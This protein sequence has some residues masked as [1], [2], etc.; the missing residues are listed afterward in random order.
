MLGSTTSGNADNAL[1]AASA[2]ANTSAN[3]S[4]S[5]L[6]ALKLVASKRQQGTSPQQARR[7]KLSNKLEEQIQLAKAQQ[8]GTEFAPTKLR[9]VHDELTG[10]SSKAQVPKKIKPWWW[11]ADN[12]KTCI[13]LRYGA[14]VVEISKGKNA[15][16]TGGIAEVITSL[17][18]LK[19]AVEAGDL[20]V[21]LAAL[22]SRAKEKTD[23]VPEP[24]PVSEKRGTLK[25]PAKAA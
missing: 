20:D 14:R 24:E 15:I 5:G 19:A 12:G 8:A 16:E 3:S 23:A 6:N 2:S 7:L 17:Q 25:L 18:I 11:T 21:I 22:S 4:A 1:T 13:T 10:L 9:V